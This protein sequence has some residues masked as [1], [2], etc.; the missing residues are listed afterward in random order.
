MAKDLTSLIQSDFDN[1]SIFSLLAVAILRSTQ[2][3]ARSTAVRP[4]R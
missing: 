1:K 2:S 3:F 4:V